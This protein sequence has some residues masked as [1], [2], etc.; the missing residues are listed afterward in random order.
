MSQ[1]LEVVCRIKPCSGETPCITACGGGL[2][3]LQAP[4]G[5]IKSNGGCFEDSWFKFG[6]VFDEWDKQGEVF[7]KCGMDFIGDVLRGQSGLLFTYGVTGGGKTH[8]MTGRGDDTG[9]LPRSVDVIF[10]SIANP[11]DKGVLYPMGRNKFGVRTELEA[12]ECRRQQSQPDLKLNTRCF[13]SRKVQKVPTNVGVSVFVSYVEIWNDY[14][15]DLLDEN[16]TSSDRLN[17]TKGIKMGDGCTAYV[18]NLIEVEV[19]STDEVMA[20]YESAQ[21]RRKVSE[22]KLNRTSS[23]AHSIF[24]IRLVMAPLDPV[25][26][27]PECDFNKVVTS[28]LVLVDLAGSERAKRTENR[29]QTLVDAGGINKSLFSLR[30][31]F[32]KMREN[33]KKAGPPQLIP[34]RDSKLTLLFKQFFEGRGKIRMIICCDPKPDDFEENA[35]TLLFAEQAQDVVIKV[36]EK[37]E[38]SCRF[39]FGC[40]FSRRDIQTWHRE[41][42]KEVKS[43]CGTMN[44]YGPPPAKKMYFGQ[45]DIEESLA[46]AEE[47][48]QYYRAMS[49]KRLQMAAVYSEKTSNFV[50][51]V[52]AVCCERDLL[53]AANEKLVGENGE[54]HQ[55]NAVL[56]GR[57]HHCQREIGALKK[58]LALY[59]VEDNERLSREE[60]GR[61]AKEEALRELE[62]RKRAL[63]FANEICTNLGLDG[64]KKNGPS[65]A[66]LRNRFDAPSEEPPFASPRS[67][68]KEV[69]TKT[70]TFHPSVKSPHA[71]ARNGYVN[72]KYHRRSQSANGRVLDHQNVRAVPTG[73]ILKPGVGKGQNIKSTANPTRQD[74]K[75]SS[76]YILTHQE[77]DQHGNISTNVF[78]GECIPTAGGGTHVQFTDIE[79]LHHESPNANGTNH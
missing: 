74:L 20:L 56:N 76:D 75:K 32:Q 52:K 43:P 55:A 61:K 15:Y 27:Y 50:E 2:V 12:R 31:C 70:T 45:A 79:R 68:R 14:C 77:V 57:V 11:L 6:Q 53:K 35:Q 16:V 40:N 24:Q 42:E 67:G 36:A 7:E 8:T 62:Q 5:Y 10:N 58:R 18:E 46:I 39:E 25:L 51:L 48:V 41:M 1:T 64:N 22:T 21:E 4:E 23:R 59:E 60:S 78:K 54:V 19:C 65:V 30:Q 34:Y 49:L 63:R 66:V 38:S 17:M 13:E 3:K 29:G 26:G 47:N 69:A 37:E 28:A 33:Q 9:I 44:L 71:S 72:P 73:T